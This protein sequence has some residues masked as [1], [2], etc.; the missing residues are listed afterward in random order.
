MQESAGEN[1]IEERLYVRSLDSPDVVMS[2]DSDHDYIEQDLNEDGFAA[3]EIAEP[4]D[5]RDISQ[6][7]GS[8]SDFDETEVLTYRFILN[9]LSEDWMNNE[10]AHH[11]SKAASDSFFEIAKKWIHKLNCAKNREGISTKIPQ[12]TSIRRKLYDT[13]VPEI[14]MEIGYLDKETNEIIKLHDVQQTPTSRFPASRYQKLFEIAYVDVS[15]LFFFFFFTIFTF[16]EKKIP[17]IFLRFLTT[18]PHHNKQL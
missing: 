11:V 16:H 5:D 10:L 8:E 13:K 9:S 2:E 1:V 15:N 7:S 4:P 14:H 17:L 12:F 3:D 6:E 18:F